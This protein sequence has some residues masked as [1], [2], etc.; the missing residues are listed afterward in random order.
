MAHWMTHF[1]DAFF[2]LFVVGIP[3]WGMWRRLKVYHVF[4]EGAKDGFQVVIDIAPYL[5]AMLVVIGML[6]ASGAFALLA[7]LLQPILTPLAIPASIIP[8]FLVRPFSGSA[9]LAVLADIIHQYGANSYDA[10]LAATALGSSE[11]T[12][13]VVAVYFGAANIVKTR[14]AVGVGLLAD[15]AG[16]IASCVICAWLYTP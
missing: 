15:L 16:F 9:S 14:Y 4:I 5:V 1:G 2:L 13:Y 12:F 3:C 6:R 10:F 11:T 7:Q 8:L